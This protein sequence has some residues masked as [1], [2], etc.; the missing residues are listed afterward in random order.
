MPA[1]AAPLKMP[2]NTGIDFSPPPAFAEIIPKIA[3]LCDEWNEAE[4]W[5]KTGELINQSAVTPSINELRYAGRRLVDACESARCGDITAADKHIL[6]AGENLAKARHDVADSVVGHI[7]EYANKTRERIG[8]GEMK[9]HFAGYEKLFGTLKHA[10]RKIAESR[11]ERGRRNEIYNGIMRE[12]LPE[13]RQLH[14][15]LEESLPAIEENIKKERMM[16]RAQKHRWRLGIA[17]SVIAAFLV[18]IR[19]VAG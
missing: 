3:A 6:E 19:I 15:S 7:S 1:C 4:E 8:A 11:K 9:R 12:D 16:E 2:K 13:L 14:D 5:I 10:A 18:L 17:I